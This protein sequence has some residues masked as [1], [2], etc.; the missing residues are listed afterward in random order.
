[1]SFRKGDRVCEE[2]P[3]DY[4]AIFKVFRRVPGMYIMS[5]LTY[6][7]VVAFLTGCD[8]AS[9]DRMLKGFREWLVDRTGYGSSLAWSALVLWFVEP[10]GGKSHSPL[11]PELEPVAIETLFRLVEEFLEHSDEVR[12]S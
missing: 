6:P 10:V 4:R 2:A 5:P 9:G 3:P 7:S 11:S 1:M 8:A 12:S